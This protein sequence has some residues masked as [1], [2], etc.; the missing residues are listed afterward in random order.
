MGLITLNLPNP[1]AGKRAGLAVGASY[2]LA[3]LSNTLV[4]VRSRSGQ[5][6]TPQTAMRASGVLTCLRI[7]CE[8][9]SAL[10][11]N[12]YRRTAQGAVLATDDPRFR[13]LHDTPNSW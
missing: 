11:L 8:D 1:P 5:Y 10:P 6:V 3:S 12:L 7:L 4:G 13:L 9:L 2:D